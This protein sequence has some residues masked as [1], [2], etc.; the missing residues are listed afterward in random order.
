MLASTFIDYFSGLALGYTA[1]P[2]ER[3]SFKQL[4]EGRK[5]TLMQRFILVTSLTSNLG[6]L[7]Y[8]KYM[9]FF[10]ESYNAVATQHNWFY[11]SSTFTDVVLPVGISFYTFQSMSYTIDVYFGKIKPNKSLID[12]SLF[13]TFFPQLV[14]GP[15]VRYIEIECELADRKITS[16]DI[17]SGIERFIL[18]FAKKILIADSMGIA[19]DKIFLLPESSLT[20]ALA[21]MGSIYYTFQIY[22]DFSGY[23]DMAIGISRMMGFHFPENFDQPYRSQNITEFWR[24]WHMTLS[25]WFRDYLYIPLGG[26]RLS[27][28]RTYLNLCIVFLLCG[29]WHGANWTFLVWGI[30]HGI[31]LS[32]ERFIKL[33]FNFTPKGIVATIITFFITIFGWILFRADTID[34]A[35]LFYRKIFLIFSISESLNSNSANIYTFAYY[36]RAPTL[37]W[38]GAALFFSFVNSEN[39]SKLASRYEL[40]YKLSIMTLF[41]FSVAFLVGNNHSPFIYFRF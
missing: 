35:L 28:N 18:G 20:P 6:F 17:A 8:F 36:N 11:L 25:H 39:L 37:F 34:Q 38:L 21:G 2:N 29:L 15:I 12:F 9:K 26:N 19:A 24:R 16:T 10:T 31:F 7:I 1:D 3:W 27:S 14:A 32:I 40:A 5:P 22:Y 30:Y 4:V 13:V 33:K 23:S 41:I